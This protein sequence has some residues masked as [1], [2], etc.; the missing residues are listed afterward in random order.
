VPPGIGLQLSLSGC[1]RTG[2]MSGGP[3]WLRY[4][5]MVPSAT[6]LRNIRE[7]PSALL[8]PWHLPV[9]GV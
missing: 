6:V 1:V 3:A 5:S 8:L 9:T 4:V 7:V 2:P